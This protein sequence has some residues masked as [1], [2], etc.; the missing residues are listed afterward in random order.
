MSTSPDENIS[1]EELR[2]YFKTLSPLT[3]PVPEEVEA[4]EEEQSLSKSFFLQGP[5]G[6]RLPDIEEAP[7]EPEK[8]TY[9]D[10]FVAGVDN[11]LESIA[12]SL[13]KFG[14]E[15]TAEWL[16][17]ITEYP[18]NYDSATQAFIGKQ[19]PDVWFDYEWSNTA[20]FL[21]EQAGSLIGSM[22]ARVSTGVALAGPGFLIA[23]P[24]GAA[25]GFAVGAIAGPAVLTFLIE[26]GP[27]LDERLKRD[28]REGEEPTW[29]DWTAAS[30][31]AGA[32]GMLE[33]FGVKNLAV[34]NKLRGKTKGDSVKQILTSGGIEAGTEATQTVSAELGAGLGTEEGLRPFKEVTEEAAAGG[35]AGGLLGSGVQTT[36][37]VAQRARLTPD[38]RVREEP[39][40]PQIQIQ[41]EENFQLALEESL[42]E[43]EAQNNLQEMSLPEIYDFAE[44]EFPKKINKFPNETAKEAREQVRDLFRERIEGLRADE[45]AS[46]S[47]L[48]VYNTEVE[49]NKEIERLNNNPEELAQERI[50]IDNPR[51]IKALA[52]QTVFEN[53]KELFDPIVYMLGRVPFNNY[54][55]KI[56]DEFDITQL[57]DFVET[58]VVDSR[59]LMGMPRRLIETKSKKQLA[60][61]LAKNIANTQLHKERVEL[62]GK[63]GLVEYSWDISEAE[64]GYGTSTSSEKEQNS[65]RLTDILKP[66]GMAVTAE[67]IFVPRVLPGQE[68]RSRASDNPQLRVN[69]GIKLNF[70]RQGALDLENNPT[71]EQQIEKGQGALVLAKDENQNNPKAKELL[72]TLRNEL[73]ESYNPGTPIEK[74]IGYTSTGDGVSYTGKVAVTNLLNSALPTHQREDVLS[75]VFAFWHNH[76]RPNVPLGGLF[77]KYETMRGNLRSFDSLANNMAADVDKAL[78]QALKDGDIKSIEEG[79]KL[80][81]SFMRRTQITQELNELQKQ[82]IERDHQLLLEELYDPET[83]GNT[84]QQRIIETKI[85]ELEDL[86]AGGLQVNVALKNL[87]TKALQNVSL[88]ARKTTNALT[89]RI[90]DEVSDEQLNEEERNI[91][92][93][94][95]D[96]YMTQSFALFEPHL[97]FNP[98][99]SKYWNKEDKKTIDE[100][101]IVTAELNKGRMGWEGEEGIKKAEK[102]INAIL[103]GQAFRRAED[104]VKL[105]GIL[106]SSSQGRQDGVAVPTGGK[107]LESRLTIP[108]AIK[109]LMGEINDPRLSIATSISRVA[110]LVEQAKFWNDIYLDNQL[111]GEM[112]F[113][114]KKVGAYTVQ[115]KQ[116]DLNPFSEWY[117]TPQVAKIFGV[118][119]DA[120]WQSSFL[121]QLYEG[122]ILAPKAATQYG[123]IVY[124][125][126]THSRNIFGAGLMF[127]AAG[128]VGPNGFAES[129]KVIGAE[130]GIPV[131]EPG[132]EVEY[133]KGEAS[134]ATQRGR[135]KYRRG[136]ELGVVFTNVQVG[137][138]LSTFSRVQQGEYNTLNALVHALYTIGN[139]PGIKD[140][141]ISP[142]GLK[143][144]IGGSI[145]AV[146]GFWLAGP[147]GAVAG[148][149]IGA[150]GFK[151]SSDIAES[152]YTGAD[153]FFKYA[154][155]GADMIQVKESLNRLNERSN[156]PDGITDDMKLDVLMQYARTLTTKAGVYNSN[157][158]KRL[159]NVTD[160]EIA[161]EEISA[162]HVRNNIPNYDYL[163]TF[164]DF[165]RRL[166]LGLFI[167]FPTEIARTSALIGQVGLKQA[168]FQL[169]DDL[170]A[171]MGLNKDSLLERVEIET[172]PN[173][174]ELI[175]KEISK[176]PKPFQGLGYGKLI[177]GGG[178]MF[179]LPAGLIAFGKAINE[180]DDEDMEAASSLLPEYAKDNQIC[181]ISKIREDGTGFDYID[182]TYLLPHSVLST[183]SPTIINAINRGEIKGNSI[184]ESVIV[185]LAN[186]AIKFS[187]AYTDVS[188]APNLQLE[189]LLN[190][191]IE[192]DKPIWNPSDG[193]GSIFNDMVNHAL[194]RA[195]PGGIRQLRDLDLAY[196]EGA[197]SFS[198]TGKTISKSRAWSKVFGFSVSE[199]NPQKSIGFEINDFKDR[200]IS[201]V[202]ENMSRFQ[203]EKGEFSKDD[204][205]SE[206][207]DAQNSFFELQQD[208]YFE[209]AAYRI[210]KLPEREIRKQ[211]KDRLKDIPGVPDNL[212]INLNKGIFSPYQLP[213]KIKKRFDATTRQMKKDYKELGKNPEEVIRVWPQQVIGNNYRKLKSAKLSLIG[214]GKLIFEIAED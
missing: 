128:Y 132:A 138:A 104:I 28:G 25:A 127:V 197:E 174:F 114:P 54:V 193:A 45:R 63:V 200:M 164:A 107:L 211:F 22:G 176:N 149:A 1:D 206:W 105:P 191:T 42:V 47:V 194:K 203:Y 189:L 192:G 110:S 19:D 210:L 50:Q 72:A 61:L 7:E 199:L 88:K 196:A 116:D 125:P 157:M 106:K 181:P 115:I 69:N 58:Y 148:A 205:L 140:T 139:R 92:K 143:R 102:H 178:I 141:L 119:Q 136:Q 83:R 5:S 43:F 70:V 170:T 167:A 82:N 60:E 6:Q 13:N 186:Y 52:T 41:E 27:T 151:K 172:S 169:S 79:E 81:M 204:I 67:V 31:S 3:A 145:G 173:N 165:I 75:K 33:S 113:S 184:P 213:K 62:S 160:L 44:R 39:V 123:M 103:T 4:P 14:M 29:K 159:R 12:V 49:I 73:P 187:Q 137:E 131:S 91:L 85:N 109:K 32:S 71:L 175:E 78:A 95:M 34:L 150:A 16:S 147:P 46:K 177:R 87:P 171:R 111:P 55:Q 57:Q 117:T 118:P 135:E 84:T 99:Y 126:G 209:L 93:L 51:A 68:N 183:I 185:G 212:L 180:F 74:F 35:I 17:E 201:Q 162:Y 195:A 129:F 24:P 208:M 65:R 153:D 18:E 48:S 56:Q 20:R 155:W 158:E 112:L 163:G 142:K 166:P 179:A 122:M 76:F 96:Q 98:K 130:L 134:P 21:M 23:G 108:P 214:S 182:L 15:G 89:Q 9:S 207:Q 64:D 86:M 53:K 8:N 202:N 100:A 133:L 144:A 156:N 198:K 30:L 97:G 40:D 80:I 38:D 161:I 11:N 152:V 59:S 37:E 101:I 188:I 90:L 120:G 168:N 121:M 77:R 10:A 94:G 2:E 124:S 36:V 154:A 66:N 26:V 190:K 146:G